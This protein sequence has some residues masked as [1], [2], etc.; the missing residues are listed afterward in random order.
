M[1]KTI[2]VLLAFLL[3]FMMLPAC[4][5]ADAE[6]PASDF[7]YEENE[8]GTITITSY[9]GTDPD[10]VIPAKI[11][12]KD[13]T[14]IG[15]FAFWDAKELLRS[16]VMPDTITIIKEHALG[17]CEKLEKVVLSNNL[18]TIEL[19]AFTNCTALKNVTLPATLTSLGNEAF[20]SCT[21]LK[22]ITIPSALSSWG[23][24][25]FWECHLE[26]V[27]LAEG[28]KR[29][30][31][32]AFRCNDLTEVV[33]P[34]SVE[35]IGIRAFEACLN[36]QSVKLPKGLQAIDSGAFRCCIALTEITIPST[37]TSMDEMAF[38]ECAALQKVYF[39]GDAPDNYLRLAIVDRA[40]NVSY[41][42]Y[43]HEGAEGFTSPE[44]NGYPTVCIP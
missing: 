41:T 3:L 16:V 21:S 30:P 24:S 28:L 26:S 15:A 13:V 9:I 19:E 17:S 4:D 18:T 12:G 39:E 14:A 40:Q 33:I 38:D 2:R 1:V 7:E 8:D 23:E 43:Y 35:K 42:I 5:R 37:V 36:L 32:Y 11:E 22:H 25:A 27:T 29:I 10:V 44:W 34:S 31:N 20:Y 6:N